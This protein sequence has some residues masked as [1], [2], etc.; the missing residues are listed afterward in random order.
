M[1]VKAVEDYIKEVAGLAKSGVATEH[2][3]RGALAALLD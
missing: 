2:T 3:F 1:S